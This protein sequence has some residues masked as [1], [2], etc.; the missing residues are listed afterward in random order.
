MP[1]KAL[2]KWYDTLRKA[3]RRGFLAEETLVSMNELEE[4][5]RL[6]LQNA[7]LVTP[8]SLVSGKS[9]IAYEYDGE[10]T[11]PFNAALY[12][13]SGQAW[14][15]FRDA[16]VAG[17]T[18][19]LS[20]ELSTQALY[21]TAISVCGTID[22]LSRSQKM[23]GTFFE[24]F[25]AFIFARRAGTEP[26]SSVPLLTHGEKGAD[27]PTDFIFN[28]DENSPSF[29]LPV[30]TST[31]ER[32]I[33][34]WAHQKLLDG[35]H[36][37]ERFLGLPFLL[38]ETKMEKKTRRVTEICTPEQWLIYQRYIARLKCVYY[39]DVPFMYLN[40]NKRF[41]R[42]AVRPVGYFFRDWDRYLAGTDP[43]PMRE[44]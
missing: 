34:L 42:L 4:M 43:D 8:T 2:K 37:I 44:S 5:S 23:A 16:M 24:Y 13:P 33:M 1:A 20:P 39:M 28:M 11:R 3:R 7:T 31:R 25:A 38:A 19:A 17:G 9:Y 18:E 12:D 32:A 21:S 29:H 22:L 27:L 10:L 15:S 35:V 36:G 30:K 14:S 26:T 6:F 41:P 40:L